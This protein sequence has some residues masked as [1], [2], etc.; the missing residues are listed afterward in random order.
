MERVCPLLEIRLVHGRGW[1]C[2][3]VLFSHIFLHL[4]HSRAACEP[5]LLLSVGIAA[6][7]FFWPLLGHNPYVPPKNASGNGGNRPEQQENPGIGVAV[8]LSDSIAALP[9]FD[10]LAYGSSIL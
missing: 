1:L 4:A 2:G 3:A 10:L 8:A 7:S 6:V 5:S 9:T